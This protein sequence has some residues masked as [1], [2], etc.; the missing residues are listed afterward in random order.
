MIKMLTT[1]DSKKRNNTNHYGHNT[2]TD[3]TGVTLNQM[4]LRICMVAWYAPHALFIDFF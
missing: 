2:A 4:T 1:K 3:I